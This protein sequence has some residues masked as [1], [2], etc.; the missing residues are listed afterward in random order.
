MS[1]DIKIIK[2]NPSLTGMAEVIND[3]VFSNAGGCKLKMQIILPWR[4]ENNTL[5]YPAVVF[6]QGSGWTFPNV[7]YEVPQLCRLASRGYV[8]ASVTHRNSLEGHPFPDCLKDVKTAIRFLRKNAGMYGIDEKRICIWG[9]SSGGN[10]ALLTAM[11]SGDERYIS[12]EYRE[13]S[14]NVVCCTACFPTTD[15]VECME[16]QDFDKGLKE[17]F[18]ALSGGTVDKNMTVLKEISPYYIAKKCIENNISADYPPIFLAHGTNDTLIPYSQSEK[19][20][21]SLKKLGVNVSMTAV[22]NAPHEGAFWSEEM[23]Q[24]IFEFIERYCEE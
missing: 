7:W 6:V 16:S 23:L 19:M 9:T 22:E 5:L 17:V 3:V 12:D 15:F 8:V 24:M 2:S 11:T 18:V 21:Y 4:S 14:D 13:Y 1:D 20:Y 10:L